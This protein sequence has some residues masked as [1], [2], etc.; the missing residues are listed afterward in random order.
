MT[1]EVITFRG[2]SRLDLDPDRTLEKTKGKLSNFVIIGW[3]KDA[4]HEF[5]FS[6][7]MADGG[8][9]LWLMELAKHKL[10]SGDY[11]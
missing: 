3:E 11:S 7:T 1:G 10:I 5:F 2:I 6:S 4:P 9:V 8:D